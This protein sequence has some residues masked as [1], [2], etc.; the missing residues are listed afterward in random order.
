MCLCV[1]TFLLLVQRI[2]IVQ[3]PRIFI[4]FHNRPEL[5]YVFTLVEDVLVISGNIYYLVFRFY[6]GKFVMFHHIRSFF[7][8][9]H[10]YKKKWHPFPLQFLKIDDKN[11][12]PRIWEVRAVH[13][14]IQRLLHVYVADMFHNSQKQKVAASVVGKYIQY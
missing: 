5:T 3:L 6:T 13:A 2:V 12:Q 10:I 4:S 14:T 7:D 11:W 1:I 9:C 8:Y